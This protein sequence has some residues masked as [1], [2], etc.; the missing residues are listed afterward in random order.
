[1]FMPPSCASLAIFANKNSKTH[2]RATVTIVAGRTIFHQP[3]AQLIM[4]SRRW[5][6]SCNGLGSLLR[7]SIVP[8]LLPSP[9]QLLPHRRDTM[10][11]WAIG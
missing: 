1:M 6:S 10:M 5:G 11:S 7:Q 9:L 3:I 4:V 2:A 8:A